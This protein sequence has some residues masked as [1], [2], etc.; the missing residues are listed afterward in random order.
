[1]RALVLEQKG[2]LRLRD[3]DLPRQIWPDDVSIRI[4]LQAARYCQFRRRRDG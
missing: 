4:H 2:K 1:M 3:I